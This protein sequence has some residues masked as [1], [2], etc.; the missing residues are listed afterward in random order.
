MFLQDTEI[1][2]SAP[3]MEASSK[4]LYW[5]FFKPCVAPITGDLI[6][7]KPVTKLSIMEKLFL[8]R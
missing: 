6:Q 5:Y 2:R 8:Q 4:L 1:H 7:V 3:A